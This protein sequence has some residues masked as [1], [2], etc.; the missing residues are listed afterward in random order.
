[1]NDAIAAMLRNYGPLQ[2]RRDEDNAL[3]EILQQIILLGLHRG[4]FFEKASFYGGTALRILYGL[5]RFSEDMDFCLT[6][7]DLHFTFEP[8]LKPVADELERYGFSAHLEEK[9]SGP[10]VAIGSAFV[11]QNTL[12]G[13]LV[14]GKQRRGPRGQLVR[15]RLEVDKLNP[16]GAQRTKKLVKLPVPFL[17]A[18][19]TEA[20]LFAGKVHALIARAYLN[21]VKGRDYY[22]FLFN[23]ARE[24]PLNLAY[25]ESKLRD[26]G[27]F[28]QAESLTKEALVALLEDK[29]RSV[30]FDQARN[31][32]RPFLHPD[33]LASLSDWNADLFIALAH[34][35]T[36]DD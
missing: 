34:T 5:D 13:L 35:L 16:P 11:K 9:R 12:K 28:V 33:R 7:P 30:D 6:E 14:I 3:H 29:F 20:S 22:D 25:L 26:S 21:R 15:V 10:D 31:D 4:R 24:I 32:V 1:M 18:T 27:H 17:V 8:Y 23:V 2:T 19:L 36:L